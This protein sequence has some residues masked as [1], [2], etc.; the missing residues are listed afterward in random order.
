MGRGGSGSGGRGGGSGVRI[1]VVCE[2]TP[3]AIA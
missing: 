2:P 1:G 3:P